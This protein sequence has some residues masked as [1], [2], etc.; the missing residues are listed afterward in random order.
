MLFF[1]KKYLLINNTKWKHNNFH[2]FQNYYN[3]PLI[4][5]SHSCICCMKSYLQEL[6][7]RR[8]C[9]KVAITTIWGHNATTV[10]HTSSFKSKVISKGDKPEKNLTKNESRENIV[11]QHIIILNLYIY[12]SWK[13]YLKALQAV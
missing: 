6:L 2:K 12:V 4:L 3:F 9:I 5:C 11:F 1:Y 7:C 8:P 13:Q 10:Y